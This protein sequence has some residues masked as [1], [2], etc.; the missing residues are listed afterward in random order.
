MP[1]TSRFHLIKIFISIFTLLSEQQAATNARSTALIDSLRSQAQASAAAAE[2]KI[3]E[4]ERQI[5]ALSTEQ[6]RLQRAISQQEAALAAGDS[7]S[8]KLRE[9]G[10]RSNAALAG[11]TKLRTELEGQRDKLQVQLEAANK[12]LQK[13]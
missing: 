9:D 10:A 5:A 11:E 2:A 13:V 4:L 8:K 12:A 3:S 6:D 7:D 1:Q